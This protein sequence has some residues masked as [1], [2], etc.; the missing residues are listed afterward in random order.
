MAP[1]LSLSI[2]KEML[3]LKTKFN[4][5]SKEVYNDRR[6]FQFI[7]ALPHIIILSMTVIAWI[8]STIML[9]NHNMHKGAYIINMGW[10]IYNFLGSFISI[11]VAYQKPILRASERININENINVKCNYKDHNFSAKVLDIS[12]KGI[13]LK[14]DLLS[15]DSN[16]KLQL[17]EDINLKL[18]NQIFKCKISRF[19]KEL[20]GL[21][22]NK[23]D[24][25]QMKLIMEIF[26]D[27]MS[28]YYRI[29]KTQE[30]IVNKKEKNSA[31]A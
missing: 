15:L 9:I 11:K 12:E 22:F 8:F 21:T 10:S 4:V 20:L 28:P 16:T 23:L 18:K 26:T 30:Y 5:T 1:H 2:L 7:V 27:N 19:N 17:G 3:F 25:K 13:G 14:L 31:I 24:V 6:Q 29:N